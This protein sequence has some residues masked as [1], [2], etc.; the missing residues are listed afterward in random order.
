MV[1]ELLEQWSPN[2]VPLVELTPYEY[3]VLA[4]KQLLINTLKQYLAI[5]NTDGTILTKERQ[6]VHT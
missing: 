2:E 5:S 6:E 1:L 3:G 4:G